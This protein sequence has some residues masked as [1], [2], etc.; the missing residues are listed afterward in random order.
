[1]KKR[2]INISI[3]I[4]LST[5]MVANVKNNE[6]NEEQTK[7]IEENSIEETTEEISN[8]IN[9]NTNDYL[10][11]I[12]IDDLNKH[13]VEDII[14]NNYKVNEIQSTQKNEE[15]I[16]KED[17]IEVSNETLDSEVIEIETS[18]VSKATQ[19]EPI[20][21]SNE[22]TS[23][24]SLND[25]N[26]NEVINENNKPNNNIENN[27]NNKPNI[28][29]IED[30]FYNYCPSIIGTSN[31][32]FY[33]SNT[34]A[35]QIQD[36]IFY[37][38]I[39][40]GNNGE[41]NFI[42]NIKVLSPTS[43]DWD[44]VHVCDPS[45]ISGNFNYQ[46][47]NYKYLMAYLGC[48]T[49]DNQKNQIGL[50]VSN[51]LSSGWTKINSNPI[52]NCNYDSSHSEFQWGVGQ[53]SLINIDDNG[54]VLL[55]YTEGAYNLTCTKVQELNLSNL[56]N[57]ESLGTITLSNNGTNDFISNA[58][59]AI[60]GNNLYMVCDTHPF[61]GNLLNCVPNTSNIYR[62]SWD[63]SLSSLES[64]NWELVFSINPSKTNFEKNHNCGLNRNEFGHLYNTNVVYT[65]GTEKDNFI[66]S[67]SSYRLNY[68]SW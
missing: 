4:L 66:N 59:F 7:L 46:G 36:N 65:S 22:I 57:I 34:N 10:K 30:G 54:H 6:Y 29:N 20:E 32:A 18:I 8:T 9:V 23:T 21:F 28:I 33:C 40:F 52:I 53:P 60:D 27:T 63:G 5:F 50:A 47:T 51:N 2:I 43:G 19:N 11:L 41:I 24:N 61:G 25:T 56:D 38:D 68:I 64:V 48:N 44:S 37:S 13:L 31:I 15:N 35:Y 1:M 17:T 3:L 12:K 58:D 55:F 67:L 62:C 45:V 42:N 39:N 26:I 14:I 49:L 16:I